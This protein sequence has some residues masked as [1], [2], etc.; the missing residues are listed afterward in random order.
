MKKGDKKIYRVGIEQF[1]YEGMTNGT[2]LVEDGKVKIVTDPHESSQFEVYFE[3]TEDS[4]RT[5]SRQEAD[6]YKGRLKYVSPIAQKEITS[7]MEREARDNAKR[8]YKT[9][10]NKEAALA[11]QLRALRSHDRRLKTP[12][13]VFSIRGLYKELENLRAFRRNLA[14]VLS[15]ISIFGGIFFLSTNVTGNAIADL[16]TK[17]TSFLG[18][19][20]LIVGLV[21][22]F[23]WVKNRK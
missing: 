23:F 12:D 3:G 2:R 16:T 6:L 18:A 9:T 11:H 1:P 15:A 8:F 5:Y 20:L 13:F 22:G 4:A 14:G 17:T 10:R 19:G 7:D 21:A